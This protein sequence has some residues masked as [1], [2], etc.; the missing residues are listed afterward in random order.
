MSDEDEFWARTPDE[1][2]GAVAPGESDADGGAALTPAAQSVLTGFLTGGISG[3]ADAIEAERGASADEDVE[4]P[5]AL[6]MAEDEVSRQGRTPTTMRSSSD[7]I[8]ESWKAVATQLAPGDNAGL[9][10][11]VRSL[12][13]DGIDCGWD[14]YDPRDTVNF[15]PPSAGLT[16][17]KL[18]SVVVPSSQFARA[19]DSLYGSPPLGVTYPWSSSMSSRAGDPVAMQNAGPDVGTDAGPPTVLSKDGIPLSD[20]T[21]FEQM[22]SGGSGG[23]WIIAVAVVIVLIVAAA[24]LAIRA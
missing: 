15:M 2:P 3:L 22:A 13:S 20:N 21:R 23:A 19:Q 12:Q 6:R 16:A 1:G 24:F 7:R 10:D 8:D 11:V 5:R 18:F 9:D 17:R 4:D 14:P